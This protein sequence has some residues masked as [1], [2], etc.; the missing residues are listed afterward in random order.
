MKKKNKVRL[1]RDLAKKTLED[2]K[3]MI[4]NLPEECKAYSDLRA[5]RVEEIPPEPPALPM[6]AD[7]NITLSKAELKIT[8]ESPMFVLRYIISKEAYIAEIEKGLIKE[9]YSRI[10]KTEENGKVIEEVKET[11][12]DKKREKDSEWLERKSELIYDMEDNTI[13]FARSKPTQWKGNK[14]STCPRLALPALGYILR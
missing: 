4:S 9:K 11:E 8:S 5:L 6:V 3:K 2:K 14:R 12:E 1:E 7:K 13:D 10:G